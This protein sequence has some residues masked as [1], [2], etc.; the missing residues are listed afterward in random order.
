MWYGIVMIAKVFGKSNFTVNCL[1]LIKMLKKHRKFGYLSERRAG[2]NINRKY[3]K[4]DLL[5]Q[6]PNLSQKAIRKKR[7][8]DLAVQQFQVQLALFIQAKQRY[9]RVFLHYTPVVFQRHTQFMRQI[10]AVNAIM[11]NHQDIS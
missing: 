5:F 2:N 4:D 8:S 7:L 10:K 11:P 1:M 3:K 6:C 9:G